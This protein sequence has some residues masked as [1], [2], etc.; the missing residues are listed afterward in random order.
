MWTY[1]KERKAEKTDIIHLQYSPVLVTLST[2]RLIFAFI[3]TF[4]VTTWVKNMG[5]FGAFGVYSGALAAVALALPLVFYYGKR[6]RLWSAGSLERSENKRA[7]K[8]KKLVGSDSD[9]DTESDAGAE[10]QSEGEGEVLNRGRDDL[11]L[12][13]AINSRWSAYRNSRDNHDVADAGVPLRSSDYN[14]D[15]GPGRPA[16]GHTQI[17]NI[18]IDQ[19]V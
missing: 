16:R 1:R 13:A 17:P 12:A 5:Y 18:T 6:I 19:A 11:E 3:L 8:G 10:G 9:S 7:A 14:S 4:N 15:S 2:F